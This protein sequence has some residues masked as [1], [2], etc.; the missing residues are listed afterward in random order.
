MWCGTIFS[1]WIL[2]INLTLMVIFLAPCSSDFLPSFK[3][4][5]TSCEKST[6]H[7][8]GFQAFNSFVPAVM[9][10]LFWITLCIFGS[11]LWNFTNFKVTAIISFLIVLMLLNVR[12]SEKHWEIPTA[13]IDGRV[14][15]SAAVFNAGLI[16]AHPQDLMSSFKSHILLRASDAAPLTSKFLKWIGKLDSREQNNHAVNVVS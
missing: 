10:E 16:L 12:G 11:F 8:T 13:L 5:F 6:Y 9:F 7:K 14:E 3:W 1:F 15:D 2:T 4:R